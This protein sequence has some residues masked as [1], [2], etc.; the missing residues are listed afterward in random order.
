MAFLKL[1]RPKEREEEKVQRPPGDRHVGRIPARAF[2]VSPDPTGFALGMAMI[3][4]A[5]PALNVVLFSYKA[6]G[7]I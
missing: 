1:S 2:P 4:D 3:A 5:I 7:H 6:L